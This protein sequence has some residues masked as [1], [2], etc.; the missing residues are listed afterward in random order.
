MA[1][2]ATVLQQKTQHPAQIEFTEQTRDSQEVCIDARRLKSAD[3]LFPNWSQTSP[4]LSARQYARI[5]HRWVAAIGL[6]GTA[7]GTHTICRTQVSLIYRGTKNLQPV[8][9]LLGHTKLERTVRYLGMRVDDAIEMAE[10]AE[11]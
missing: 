8:Q 2:K 6:D 4:H 10:K 5:V 1:A 11:V 7:Y 3:F 9:L